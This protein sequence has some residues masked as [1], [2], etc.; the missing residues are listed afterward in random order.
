MAIRHQAAHAEPAECVRM[1]RR[2][3]HLR[4]ALGI[5]PQILAAQA[6]LAWELPEDDPERAD[7]VETCS[8]G[9]EELGIAWLLG[10]GFGR[11]EDL[12]V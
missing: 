6:A 12:E 3:L 2:S 4:G 1:L 8:A 9:A 10:G 7:L 5:R 11:T